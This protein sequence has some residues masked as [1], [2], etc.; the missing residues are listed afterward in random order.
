MSP[1][2]RAATP[3]DVPAITAI[4]AAEV[5]DLVNTYEYD[6]PDAAEMLRRMQD[7]LAHGHVGARARDGGPGRWRSRAPW[8]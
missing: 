1:T 7:L 6:P 3:D 5:R 4:Y 8:A 2:I